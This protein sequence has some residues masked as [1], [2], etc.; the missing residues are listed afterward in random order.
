MYHANVPC[1]SRRV[2]DHRLHLALQV[3]GR[4]R[5]RHVDQHFALER[6]RVRVVLHEP[7]RAVG[8]VVLC[9]Q[10]DSID[11]RAAVAIYG[12]YCF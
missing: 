7:Q 5:E 10:S 9:N 3:G 8:D 2:P 4:G 6:L 1:S 11:G 12:R